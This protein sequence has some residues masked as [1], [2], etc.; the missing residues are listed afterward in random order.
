MFIQ[1]VLFSLTILVNNAP[2]TLLMDF[3]WPFPYG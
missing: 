2:N 3:T 1:F